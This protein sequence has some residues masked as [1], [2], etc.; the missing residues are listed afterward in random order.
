MNKYDSDLIIR[1]LRQASLKSFIRREA[2]RKSR[3][4]FLVDVFKNGKPKTIYRCLC[5]E[6]KDWFLPHEIE[7][8]HEEEIGSFTGDWNE[9][10]NKMIPDTTENLQVLCILCHKKKTAQFNTGQIKM[11]NLERR[12]RDDDEII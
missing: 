3:R 2:I 12:I 4:K 10:I 5:A 6:C 11:K 7:V 1:H 8:D 9:Y